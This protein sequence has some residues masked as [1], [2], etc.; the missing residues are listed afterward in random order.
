VVAHYPIAVLIAA[1]MLSGCGQYK[2]SPYSFSPQNVQTLKDA[3][4]GKVKLGSFTE[5]PG[6]KI[7]LRAAPMVSPYGT[8][9]EYLKEALRQELDFAG[10]LS[11]SSEVEISGVIVKNTFDASGINEGVGELHAHIRVKRGADSV[12]DKIVSAT[13]RWE[14]AFAAAVAVPK[15][16]AEYPNLVRNLVQNLLRDP[17]FIKAIN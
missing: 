5:S 3:G 7:T 9:A 13:H 11:T 4:T 8:Y 15:A 1:L 6:T 16:L 12:Y 2:T 10:R 14:S 17:E